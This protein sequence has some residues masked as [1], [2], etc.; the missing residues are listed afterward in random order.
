MEAIL[1]CHPAYTTGWVA[2][3]RILWHKNTKSPFSCPK[4]C[5]TEIW[6]RWTHIKD[7]L[8]PCYSKFCEKTL[9][10]QELSSC[11]KSV[12]WRNFEQQGSN[13]SFMCVYYDNILCTQPP[14][15]PLCVYTMTI[16]YAHSPH[17][18]QKSKPSVR[19]PH[20]PNDWH[21]TPDKYTMLLCTSS[22]CVQVD[23]TKTL[24]D[25]GHSPSWQ[26]ES[27]LAQL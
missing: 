20:S 1:A 16:Y 4:E 13:W 26:K 27:N 8:L 7:Q 24:S 10:R 12:F 5:S 18:A 17:L 11:L 23:L 9:F 21:N 6:S 14:F 25:G 3:L 15:G 22:I 19:S 2:K